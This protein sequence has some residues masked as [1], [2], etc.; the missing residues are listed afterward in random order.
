M[1]RGKGVTT[2]FVIYYLFDGREGTGR[3]G[4]GL[5]LLLLDVPFYKHAETL[6]TCPERVK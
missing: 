6:P 4:K 5:S 1:L 2:H 3:D